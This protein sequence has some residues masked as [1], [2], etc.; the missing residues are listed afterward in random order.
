MVLSVSMMDLTAALRLTVK[1]KA[2]MS[3]ERD[4]I[5]LFWHINRKS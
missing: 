1:L 4:P 2:V 5:S 3:R